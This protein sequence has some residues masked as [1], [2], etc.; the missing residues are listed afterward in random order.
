[1]AR[2][3]TRQEKQHQR[4][5]EQVE[6]G[7]RR[8]DLDLALEALIALPTEQ[9]G[10]LGPRLAP[11]FR[12]AIESAHRARAWGRLA[13]LAV[14]AERVP[15]LVEPGSDP[16]SAAEAWWPLVL[17]C[18]RQSDFDR[19]RRLWARLSPEAEARAPRLA[20]AVISWLEGKGTMTAEDFAALALP[21][22]EA[23]DPRLGYDDRPRA[24]A[25]HV[26]PAVPEEAERVVLGVRG[27]E[28]WP[29]FA[30]LMQR[31]GKQ[32][33]A[34]IAARVLVLS[35]QL[36][37]R[38]LLVRMA[39]GAPR[40]SESFSL[41][42]FAAQQ[43][44]SPEPIESALV[45]AFRHT[46]RGLGQPA[47]RAQLAAHLPALAA[48][49]CRLERYRPLVNDALG[50]LPLAG[51]PPAEAL[52]LVERLLLAVPSPR[53]VIQGIGFWREVGKQTDYP[54]EDHLL[55][56][57]ERLSP[58]ALSPALLRTLTPPQRTLLLG[59]TGT[60]A[61]ASFVEQ[62]FE[63][64][65]SQA[66]ES[67]RAALAVMVEE[68]AAQAEDEASIYQRL[69]P[70]LAGLARELALISSPPTRDQDA[71]LRTARKLAPRALKYNRGLLEQ[72]VLSSRSEAETEALIDA[73][74]ADAR[75]IDPWLVACQIVD[76]TQMSS[77]SSK[78]FD[79]MLARFAT[80]LEALARGVLWLSE[81]GAPRTMV[82]RI[83]LALLN[84]HD[85]T[86]T[87]THSPL[88]DEALPIAQRLFPSPARA[89]NYGAKRVAAAKAKKAAAA[90][91]R[92]TAAEAKKAAAAEAK[93]AAAEAKKAAAAEAKKAAAEAKKAARTA[94]PP[95]P[96]SP[97]PARRG[98][99]T[100]PGQDKP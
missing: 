55:D 1:M 47:E 93:K 85:A 87:G 41:L 92:K 86:C 64:G 2:S 12:G 14:R 3:D 8:G 17:G 74:L 49:L 42:L 90:A 95:T 31:W 62:V 65:W 83:S 72:L 77:A 21:S 76:T 56:A 15:S 61:S 51:W 66:D 39:S 35:G 52:S 29:V 75:A 63:A 94:T 30:Q 98:A 48:A 13:Q 36:A 73:F 16:R 37:A 68:L 26:L 59:F 89:N 54:P 27:L 91:A 44:P 7:L 70:E 11:L 82:Q 97:P 6:K 40:T 34:P 69:P 53:L 32:L 20:R 67:T 5:I 80:D 23:R 96:D 10:A 28:P 9:Q 78:L 43:L 84:L 18:G 19:A 25:E 24:R 88:L 79:R 46:L 71:A 99:R 50:A 100:R 45:L 22:S 81:A 57:L 38:E 58:A 60:F 33:P 4:A